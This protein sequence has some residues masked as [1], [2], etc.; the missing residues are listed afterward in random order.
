[1]RQKDYQK[2]AMVLNNLTKGVL[3]ESEIKL[4]QD[5]EVDASA[6]PCK[7]IRLFRSNTKVDVFNDKII[8]LDK[9]KITAALESCPGMP[10]TAFQSKL[11]FKCQIYDDC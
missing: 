5:R 11:K 6:I 2:F 9:K 3:N 1:M 10:K 8:Q 4:F 7:A